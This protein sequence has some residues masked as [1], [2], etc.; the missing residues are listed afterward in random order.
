MKA[1]KDIKKRQKKM[2]K[3]NKNTQINSNIKLRVLD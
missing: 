2:K 1:E 3:L